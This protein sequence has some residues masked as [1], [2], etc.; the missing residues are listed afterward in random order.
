MQL[1]SAKTVDF[2]SNREILKEPMYDAPEG[3]AMI[4][5]EDVISVANSEED[6]A[7]HFEVNEAVDVE[8]MEPSDDGLIS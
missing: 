6:S 5:D 1:S 2:V 8:W 3:D 7:A 4:E